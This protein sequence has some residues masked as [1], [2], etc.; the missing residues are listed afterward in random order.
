MTH[1]AVSPALS[2]SLVQREA[3]FDRNLGFAIYGL[4]L[5]SFLVPLAPAIAGVAIAYNR[6]DDAEPVGHT[7]FDHQVR[8]FWISLGLGLLCLSLGFL[9]V[10]SAVTGVFEFATDGAQWDAWDLAALDAD[11]FDI[12]GMTV[13]LGAASVFTGVLSV[14]WL[15]VASLFGLVRLASDQPVGQAGA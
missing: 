6:R 1:A 15:F 7:H 5:L 8:T 2:A 14:L 10:V 12:D 11:S 4:F 13:A 9:T 3:S